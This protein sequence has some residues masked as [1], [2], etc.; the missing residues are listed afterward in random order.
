MP[1]APRDVFQ[2]TPTAARPGVRWILLAKDEALGRWA[3]VPWDP[4]I[5]GRHVEFRAEKM[6]AK[7]IEEGR[8]E[9]VEKIREDRFEMLLGGLYRADETSEEVRALIAPLLFKR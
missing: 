2:A 7:S 6:I 1:F 4:S 8:L 9:P 5:T 3:V